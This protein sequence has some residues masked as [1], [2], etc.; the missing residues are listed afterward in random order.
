[1]AAIKFG[2]IASR[3]LLT[4]YT[5]KESPPIRRAQYK[6][7]LRGLVLFIQRI[8]HQSCSLRL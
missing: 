3:K 7:I 1:M 4:M 6:E 2:G 5:N 8:G